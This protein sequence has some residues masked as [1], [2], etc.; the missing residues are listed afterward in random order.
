MP[1][2]HANAVSFMK[3]PSVIIAYACIAFALAGCL[4]QVHDKVIAQTQSPTGKWTATVVDRDAGVLTGSII[5]FLHPTSKR[6]DSGEALIAITD[7]SPPSVA[8]LD[9]AT[10]QVQLFNGTRHNERSE[11]YGVT[12]RYK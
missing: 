2:F 11:A 6:H 10:L 12:I 7:G 3:I 9:D 4:A 1:N 8:F 5:V